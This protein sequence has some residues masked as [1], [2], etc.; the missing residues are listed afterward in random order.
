MNH[1]PRRRSPS[2]HLHIEEL[3]LHGFPAGDRERIARAVERELTRLLEKDGIPAGWHE[4][5]AIPRLDAGSFTVERG[6]T[7]EGI[8]RDISR[9]LYGGMKR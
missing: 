5:T 8:G 7:P 2:V 9:S 4:G 6:A 1:S 3:V